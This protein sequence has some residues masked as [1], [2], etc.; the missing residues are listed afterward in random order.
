MVSSTARSNFRAGYFYAI[1]VV[2]TGD[3]MSKILIT[4]RAQAEPSPASAFVSVALD[5]FDPVYPVRRKGTGDV[6]EVEHDA[7]TDALL[8]GRTDLRTIYQHKSPLHRV[9]TG[10]GVIYIKE[11]GGCVGLR[12]CPEV[13]GLS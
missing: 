7:A 5:F 4:H 3:K 8:S 11:D 10:G 6:G 2:T 9:Q 1:R 12:S 13:C